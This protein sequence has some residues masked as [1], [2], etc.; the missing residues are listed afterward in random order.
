MEDFVQK[1]LSV[2]YALAFHTPSFCTLEPGQLTL[3]AA[4][5]G[6]SSPCHSLPELLVFPHPSPSSPCLPQWLNQRVSNLAVLSRPPGVLML[7]HQHCLLTEVVINLLQLLWSLAYSYIFTCLSAEGGIE[8]LSFVLSGMVEMSFME[9][10]P[11]VP[12]AFQRQ[13]LHVVL[14]EARASFPHLLSQTFCSLPPWLRPGLVHEGQTTT[15][16]WVHGMR[17][18]VSSDSKKALL[19]ESEHECALTQR[20]SDMQWQCLIH[21]EKLLLQLSI[22]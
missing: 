7:P 6:F 9:Q 19:S 2:L 10:N 3:W 14:S 22:I 11:R 20:R 17:Q 13:T 16:H 4:R 12:F 5:Q 18:P 15:H 1:R 21:Y 8:L